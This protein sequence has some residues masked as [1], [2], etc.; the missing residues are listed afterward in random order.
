HLGV[1]PGGGYFGL[2]G[3][4]ALTSDGM[5]HEQVITTGADFAPPVRFLPAPNADA[6][7]LNYFN[8][9]IYSATGRACSGV[10]NG[11]WSID[12]TSPDY[13]V[14][15]FNSGKAKP[16][17]LSG[18]LLTPDGISLIVTGPG[19][20]AADSGAPADSVVAIG[21]DMKAE[22]WYT[23]SGGMGSYQAVSPITFTYKDKQL[24][25]APGKDGSVSLLDA[26]SLGGADHRTALSETPAL[27]NPGA[28]HGWD[29]FAEYQDKEGTTWVYASISTGITLNESGVKLNGSAEHGGIVAFR[30]EENGGQLALTPVWA[31]EDMVNPAPPRIANGVVVVLA[32]GD[33]S[34][35][36]TLLMLDAATGA[37]L[38]SSKDEISTYTGLSGVAVGDSHAFFTDH[39]NILYSFGIGMEH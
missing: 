39:N 38:Y 14:K 16:L 18:P 35:H 30:L 13:S 12:L 20:S 21:G 9:A 1:A 7:S 22:N 19:E 25:V 8:H 28:K 34:T 32:G 36:A 6:Y 27:A 4:Y 31:S 2:K 10:A 23:P 15:S 24:V 5:L 11:L 17:N 3:I 26:A 29:G 33:A 37:E